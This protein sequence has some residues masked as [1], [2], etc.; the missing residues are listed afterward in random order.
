MSFS[1]AKKPSERESFAFNFAQLLPAG[2]TIASAV[3]TVTVVQ[4]TDSNPS[5]MVSGSP[6]IQGSKV[7]QL[8]IGGVDGVEYCLSCQATFSDGQKPIL[9]DTLWVRAACAA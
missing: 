2:V 9:C 8:I 7:S 4:G 6:L 1:P 5:A 3:W